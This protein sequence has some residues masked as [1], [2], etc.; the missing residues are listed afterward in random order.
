[1][2]SVRTHALAL[3]S[4]ALVHGL[5]VKSVPAR[6]ITVRPGG[7]RSRR[8]GEEL[9][10]SGPLPEH[11]VITVDGQLVT[12]RARTVVDLT[13][14]RGL[15]AGLIAWDAARWSA[16]RDR[17]LAI[18]D[19]QT[20]EV[21]ELLARRHGIGRAREARW[22]SSAFSESPMET[23]SLFAMRALGIPE[24]QQQYE[25]LTPDGQS[26]GFADFGWEDEGVLG[27]YDGDGKYG[28]LARPGETPFEV[29]RREKRRQEAM[30]AQ[31]WVFARWGKEELALPYLLRQRI[32]SAFEI[33]SGRRRAG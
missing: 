4:A 30:E 22:L 32:T 19:D 18:F 9:A 25:V 10:L 24:P 26:L 31:G 11:H 1:M 17:A 8:H 33:A 15:E 28:H 23:R 7:G 27:E 6:V 3:E 21:L 16:R 20:D 12:T 14:V 13:R 5:P 2:A 29:M